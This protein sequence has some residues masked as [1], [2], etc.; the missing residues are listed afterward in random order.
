MNQN[1]FISTTFIKDQMPLKSALDQINKRKID[2]VE[3]GSNH[4]YEENYDYV[5]EFPYEYIIH[6]YFPIPKKSFVVNIASLDE[7]I[8][9]QSVNHIKK[10]IDYCNK[11]NAK[12]YTFHPGFISD[13][14]PS[15]QDSENYDFKW[16]VIDQ[17]KTNFNNAKNNMFISLDEITN[18]ARHNNIPIAIETEGSFNKKEYL[19]MQRPEEYIELM[20]KYSSDEIG[21]NLNIGHLNLAANAFN[22]DKLKFVDLIQNYLVAME[23]SHNNGIEDQHLPLEKNNWYWDL[24]N[25]MRFKSLFKILEFRNTSID[26]I[27]NNIKLF[28]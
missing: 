28:R 27:I 9:K 6:N 4:C 17:N 14:I 18:Y 21:I 24:I 11:I 10:A 19:L 7:N 8:R 22:F 2:C 25:D 1:I 13:P 23:L 20:R 16:N 26:D 12:L 15:N 5:L 3:I